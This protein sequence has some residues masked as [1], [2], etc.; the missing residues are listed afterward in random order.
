MPLSYDLSDFEKYD[1][2]KDEIYTAA[3][4]FTAILTAICIIGYAL[5]RKDTKRLAWTISLIN[6]FLLTVIGLIYLWYKFPRFNE[7]F[8]FGD[9][10]REHIHS[11]NNYA[12]LTCLWFGL[13]NIFDLVFGTI[14][15]PK[16]CGL[17]TAYVHHTA[18]IWIMWTCTTGNGL[19]LTCTPF[20]TLFHLTLIEEL[21]TFLLS[22]G[23]MVPSLRT[24]LGF[25]ITFFFCRILYHGYFFLYGL[26]SGVDP[27]VI[28]IFTLTMT[29]HLSWFY[30]WFVKYCFPSKEK[31]IASK[32]GKSN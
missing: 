9:N 8:S 15:Y 10:A 3:G 1:L 31:K 4:I 6:S 2:T 7:I 18:F 30:T 20:A 16:Y 26:K 12:T 23:S 28:G 24:D 21:P 5:F 14:F 13:V 29:L 27:V 32:A 25:G 19:F 22:L 11:I 17:V